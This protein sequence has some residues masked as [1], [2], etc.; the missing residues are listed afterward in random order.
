M[1][2]DPVPNHLLPAR[3]ILAGVDQLEAAS[4]GNGEE[5]VAWEG[6][7]SAC[8]PPL[9]RLGA[10]ALLGFAAWVATTSAVVLLFNL[11]GARTVAGQGIPVPPE[12]FYA[13][14]IFSLALTLGGYAFWLVDSLRGYAAFSRILRRNGLDPR[15][16]TLGGLKAYSDEQLLALRSRFEKTADEKLKERLG[17]TFGFRADDSFSLGPLSARPGTFEMGTLRVEW[18]TALILDSGKPMPEVSWWTEGRLGLLPRQADET[19]KLVYAQLYT[20]HSVRE[21]KR[22]YGYRADHW[23]RTVPEGKLW[24]AVRDLEESHH[25]QYA[26]SRRPGR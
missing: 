2:G 24:D 4:I 25:I 8:A 6:L 13:T 15:R 19:R 21:L 7:A 22:R 26:L 1:A 17:R 5:R 12:A 11:F 14:I 18:E 16:P 3:V 9:R 20:G 10:F 23:H